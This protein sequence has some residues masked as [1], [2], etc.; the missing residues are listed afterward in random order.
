MNISLSLII[1]TSYLSKK[2]E[3]DQGIIYIGFYNLNDLNRV[4]WDTFI[5]NSVFVYT[6]VIVFTIL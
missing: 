1:L 6:L 2:C 3:K 4:I 5:L